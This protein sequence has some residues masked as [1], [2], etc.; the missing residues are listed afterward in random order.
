MKYVGKKSWYGRT[1]C[2]ECLIELSSR[3]KNSE[4]TLHTFLHEL[5]HAIFWAMDKQKLFEAEGLVDG[6][7]S[8]LMQALTTAE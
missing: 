4:E 2:N 8:L 6:H 5:N 1:K 3:C 7:A